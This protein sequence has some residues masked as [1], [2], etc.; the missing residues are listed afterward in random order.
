MILFK[1]CPR[2]GGDLHVSGDIYGPYNQCV[3]CGHVVDL[4]PAMVTVPV[5]TKAPSRRGSQ[6]A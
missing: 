2:C 4:K 3:Q 5:K 1:A 6:A